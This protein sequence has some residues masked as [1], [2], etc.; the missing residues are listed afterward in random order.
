[1]GEDHGL[2]KSGRARGVL[3]VDRIVPVEP[4]AG[5]LQPAGADGLAG[6]EQ[7][8]PGQEA[9]AGG[10]GL[11]RL[12]GIVDHHRAQPGQIG[13]ERLA[14]RPMGEARDELEQHRAVVAAAKPRDQHEALDLGLLQGIGQLPEPIGRIDGDQDHAD[15]GRGELQLQPLDVVRCPG[16]DTI[17]PL[18][19]Q[20]QQPRSDPVHLPRQLRVGQPSPLGQGDHGLA[21]GMSGGDDGE[22]GRDG[23]AEQG[24]VAA[25][26]GVTVCGAAHGSISDPVAISLFRRGPN[27][28]GSGRRVPSESSR[29]AL[30][31]P[32]ALSHLLVA[33]G[34]VTMESSNPGFEAREAQ[35][36][37]APVFGHPVDPSTDGVEV[38]EDQFFHGFGHGALTE[39]AY[40]Q[41]SGLWG[42]LAGAG[43]LYLI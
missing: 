7:V 39:P 16:P 38:L 33:G 17:T 27:G 11:L 1:M 10:L 20:A 3:D 8:G 42:P 37:S 25:A 4:R 22:M 23:G 41:Y 14:G 6:G 35:L 26:M 13:T 21:L 32:I 12:G 40:G 29:D 30:E 28:A 19:A 36:D 15:S 24:P 31:T 18:E 2:G 5:G 43:G 9:A 34:V